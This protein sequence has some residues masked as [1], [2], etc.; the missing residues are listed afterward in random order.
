[1]TLFYTYWVQ[2]KDKRKAFLKAQQTLRTK[3]PHPYYWGAFVLVGE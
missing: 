2:L 1:M 3:Y